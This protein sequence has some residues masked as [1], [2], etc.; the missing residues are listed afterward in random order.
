MQSDSSKAMAGEGEAG[1]RRAAGRPQPFDQ[2]LH[3][4]LHE[5]YGSIASE[6]LPDDFVS[7]IDREM[8]AKS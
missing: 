7:L 4:Q 3:K 2:W 6:P 8:R 5:L 1:S